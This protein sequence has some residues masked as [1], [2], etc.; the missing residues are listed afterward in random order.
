[1]PRISPIAADGLVLKP[2]ERRH[3]SSAD[4][5]LPSCLARPIRH[6]WHAM[7]G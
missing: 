6:C 3:R 4:Q 2:Q 5:W 7:S 1:M